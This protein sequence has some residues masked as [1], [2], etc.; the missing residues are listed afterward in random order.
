MMDALPARPTAATGHLL[1]SALAWWLT[2]LADMVPAAFRRAGHDS[3]ILDL[4]ADQAFL[5]V[6]QR[7]RAAP[8]SITLGDAPA[9]A[10]G[11]VAALLR[12]HGS[13][14]SV[15]VRIDPARLFVTTLDLPRAAERSLTA[16]LRHQ[17]ERL[18]P[19]PAAQTCFA[20]RVLPR[21]ADAATLTVVVAVAKRSAIEQALAVARE[22]GLVPK[23]IVAAIAEA[24]SAPL[25]IWQAD[26][27]VGR[28]AARRKL[29][30]AL[31]AAALALAVA[32]YGLHVHR[33]DQ[34]R[35]GL[36]EAVSKARQEA[37]AT[38]A[39]GQRIQQSA[40]ALAFLRAR[41]QEADPLLVLDRL[42]TL[43]PLDSWVTDLTLHG[44]SVEIVGAAR[45]ATD[46]VA[47]IEGSAMFGRTRFR[48]P[49]TLLPDG[50]AE[51]FDLTFDVK[52]ANPP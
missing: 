4:T 19:L 11:R 47:P 38:R 28:T 42:T 51:R 26:R 9:E 24:G 25:T 7:G 37:D 27:P 10:R 2:E 49:I 34:I 39:L 36:Q 52:A 45:R 31:E 15:T 40:E 5:V 50:R 22:T 20:H 33:L 17:V 6:Q 29:L 18:V 12:R 1:R 44:G 21:P 13:A 35:E 16:V 8:I 23:R 41:R 32:A 48:S 14:G 46:L 3:A 43:L 30:R